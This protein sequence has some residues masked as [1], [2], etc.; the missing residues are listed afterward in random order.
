[1]EAYCK[2]ER[3]GA[4]AKVD[5]SMILTSNPPKYKY[6]C[7]SC[8]YPGYTQASTLYNTKGSKATF[9]A[10]G[11]SN[12]SLN[13]NG[14]YNSEKADC[15][16]CSHASVCKYKEEFMTKLASLDVNEDS[17]IRLRC[18]CVHYLRNSY[19]TIMYRHL[20]SDN[21]LNVT[22]IDACANCDFTKKLNTEGAYIGDSPC[23]FCS[24]NPYRVSCS[25]T[26]NS[27]QQLGKTILNEST[28]TSITK[29]IDNV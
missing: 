21:T 14:L 18:D 26:T 13:G 1:M 20:L 9:K 11:I 29:E 27:T 22:G 28:C 23:E 25:N 10:S 3:C 2:C 12:I 17:F 7:S 6:E 19:N 4:E 16:S 5:T 15:S 8:N 24:H